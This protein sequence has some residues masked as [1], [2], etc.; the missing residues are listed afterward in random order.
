M[1]QNLEH[2]WQSLLSRD[3]TTVRAAWDT[4]DSTERAAVYAHLKRMVTEPDWSEPQRI[5]AQA[6]LDTL[7]SGEDGSQQ[8][9]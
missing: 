7:A 1:S 2:L 8:E 5:S 3:S 4:L 6:A 9:Q